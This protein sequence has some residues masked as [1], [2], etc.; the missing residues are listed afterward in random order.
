MNKLFLFWHWFLKG[1]GGPAGLSVM[2]GNRWALFHLSVGVLLSVLVS[3]PLD[4]IAGTILLPLAGILVGMSFAWAANAQA[5]LQTREIAQL[6]EFHPGGFPHYAYSFQAAVLSILVCIV[7]WGLAGFGVF[8]STWPTPMLIYPYLVTKVL[9][10][11]LASL[12]VRECWNVVLSSQ[13]LMIA[14]HHLKSLRKN[15]RAQQ[16]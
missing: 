4:V 3:R 8:D 12:S 16:R 1:S 14:R 6:S 7:V 10:F 11:S 13:R 9:L 15:R 2:L 5:L